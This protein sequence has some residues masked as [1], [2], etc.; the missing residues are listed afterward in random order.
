MTLTG[1]RLTKTEHLSTAFTGEGA[2]LYG[3][4]WNSVGTRVVYLASTLSLATLELLVHIEDVET[5]QAH[6]SV[7]PVRFSKKLIQKTD[8]SG[9]PPHWNSPVVMPSSQ[10]YGDLWIQR[11]AKAVL[12]VPSAIV[13]TES[14]YLLNPVHP[15]FSE[16]QIGEPEPFRMDNRL[17]K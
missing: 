10:L 2:K 16:I 8:P 7:F 4:R 5:L 6:Y 15:R 14:N 17:W 1:Y 11:K 9:L 3:G 13:P 12:Q